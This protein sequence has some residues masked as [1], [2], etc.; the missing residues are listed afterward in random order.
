MSTRPPVA[1]AENL[2]L[3]LLLATMSLLC[4]GLV[5]VASA[6]IA[7]ASRETGV[8]LY[9]FWRQLAYFGV[10][11]GVAVG[12]A[13]VSLSVWRKCAPGLC[14]FGLLL[15]VLVLVPGVGHEVNGSAR[16][17]KLGALSMQPSEPM[18]LW[19]IVYLAR[20]LAQPRPHRAPHPELLQPLLV[21][22]LSG[23]LLLL[24]PDFG[25]TAVLIATALGMMFLAGVPLSK[26]A[27]W[28][29]AAVAALAAIMI[30]APYRIDRLMS[31][32]N[33][34]ADPYGS[35]FQ[36]T[37]ALIAFGRGEWLGVGLGA[38]VQKLFYLPEAHTDFLFAVLAEE[39][40]FIGAAT[41][42]CLFTFV[43][44]RAIRIGRAA[45]LRHDPFAAYAAYGLGLLIGV[46]AFVNI[47]V[48]MG[49]LPTKGLTLP[50]VSYGGSSLVVNC[51]A[52]ALLMR[53]D[54]DTRCEA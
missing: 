9:Y 13:L 18:K 39:L 35:G 53:I 14:A 45:Q 51:V 17:L 22:A 2:D 49:V 25:A 4:I 3:G 32:L 16:W 36:L 7:T 10:A 21:L 40:G 24:E 28:G 19:L 34:W 46:E 41:V 44:W 1:G 5:M 11:L 23:V 30:A 33:P 15:L 42:I 43:V 20:S 52:I 54:Y 50:L 6:S 29:I 31:F 8:P 47:G 26:F 48:N 27:T 38:G 37:Q 12:G